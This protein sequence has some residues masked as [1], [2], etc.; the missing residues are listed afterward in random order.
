MIG[1]QAAGCATKRGGVI[2]LQGHQGEEQDGTGSFC[3]LSVFTIMPSC[4]QRRAK[5]MLENF[6][7]LPCVQ[8]PGV[9]DPCWRAVCHSWEYAEAR[10][11]LL[12]VP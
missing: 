12:H 6:A 11:R 1:Y 9:R 5:K 4:N 8:L 7:A 2:G 3:V 10:L